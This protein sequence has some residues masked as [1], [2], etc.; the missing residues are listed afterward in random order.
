MNFY[1]ILGI[2]G[3]ADDETIRRAIA[4]QSAQLSKRVSM[5]V[6]LESRHEAEKMLQAIGEARQTLLDRERRLVYDRSLPGFGHGGPSPSVM[7][8]ERAKVP[9][10]FCSELIFESAKKCR[11]CNEWLSDEPAPKRTTRKLVE[12]GTKRVTADLPPKRSPDPSPEPD[13][14]L[15]VLDG[16]AKKSPGL[17]FALGFFLGPL[18]L[19]YVGFGTAFWM[20]VAMI[21]LGGLSGGVLAVVGWFACGAVGWI[22]AQDA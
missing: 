5:A 22:K 3:N 15:T 17:A 11:Y 16:K 1:D 21:V 2:P 14:M 4:Q 18:G 7:E 6:S 12:P 20:F 8:A 13:P 10:P 19:L 9:C